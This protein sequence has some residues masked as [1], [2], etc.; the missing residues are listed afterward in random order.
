M[1][2]APARGEHAAEHGR[3]LDQ[4]AHRAVEALVDLTRQPGQPVRQRRRLG[5]QARPQEQA[6]GEQ[7]GDDEGE[8]RADRHA[9]ADGEGVCPRDDR[10]EEVGERHREEDGQGEATRQPDER[11][12]AGDRHEPDRLHGGS[13]AS[14]RGAGSVRTTGL[15]RAYDASTRERLR[16][17]TTAIRA[18]TVHQRVEVGLV[19]DEQPRRRG[20]PR[21][22]GARG[23][24][25]ERELTERVAGAQ[26]AH[27][28]LARA[29]SPG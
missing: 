28:V 24:V 5:D 9:P 20:D 14:G 26:R 15:R 7:H 18:S 25:D 2:P 16:M 3:R 27:D 19:E 21:A 4:L 29:A 10:A 13:A 6:R 8:E 1:D 17:T 22:A 12:D 11:G 23:L